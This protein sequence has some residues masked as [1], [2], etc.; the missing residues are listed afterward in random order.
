MTNYCASQS[1][2]NSNNGRSSTNG[3]IT[4]EEEAGGIKT[5]EAAKSSGWMG[6]IVDNLNN[7]KSGFG[8]KVEM[9]TDL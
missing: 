2:Q 5:V 9:Q 3:I 4:N 8:K 6:G 1:N 7:W